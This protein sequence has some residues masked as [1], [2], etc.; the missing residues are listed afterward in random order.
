MPHTSRVTCSQELTGLRSGGDQ[1]V[2]TPSSETC[3][4]LSTMSG[5]IK[6]PT[7]LLD[8]FIFRDFLGE[9]DCLSLSAIIDAK[10]KPSTL[11][12]AAGK[13]NFRTNETCTF[14]RADAAI[15]DLDARISDLLGLDPQLGEALQGQ[16][17]EEGQEYKPHFDFLD[18][19]GDYWPRQQAMGGQRTWTALIFLNVPGSGGETYF[20]EI[21]LTVRPRL[22]SLVVWNNLDEAGQPNR[23][24]LHQGLPVKGGRKYILT[25]WYRERP[26]GRPAADSADHVSH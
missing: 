25:K 8:M 18:T 10:R 19:K 9:P 14:D 3:G 22:G 7:P 13:P 24:S 23:A 16:S 2:G 5:S 11:F 1:P 26:W 6:V 21:D 12:N 20:P 15:S 17:Y 4:R